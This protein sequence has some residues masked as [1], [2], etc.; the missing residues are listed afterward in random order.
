MPVHVGQLTSDVSLHDGDLPLS[1]A[2]ME[3]LVRLVLERLEQKQREQQLA[4][5]ATTIRRQATP[6][7]TGL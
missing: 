7:R 4:R 3:R 1:E 2:Q 6:H 5:E